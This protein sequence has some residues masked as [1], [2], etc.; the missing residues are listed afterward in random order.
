MQ[1]FLSIFVVVVITVVCTAIVSGDKANQVSVRIQ[2]AQ[3]M[4]NCIQKIKSQQYM[5]NCIKK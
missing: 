3:Y 4:K 5:K 1:F 2:L